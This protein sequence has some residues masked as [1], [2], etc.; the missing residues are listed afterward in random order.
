MKNK[1]KN[2]FNKSFIVLFAIVNLS[3][4]SLAQAS[5]S[6][7]EL[8]TLANSARAKEGLGNLQTNT[9][10]ESAAFAKAN[11][12][13]E[14][15]YFAHASPDGKTPWDF[16]TEAGYSYVY[17]G[18]NLAIGYADSAELHNAWM[19]SAS[20]RDNI[21][22]P[23]FRD[24]GVAVVSGQYQGGETTVVVQMF[25]STSFSQPGSSGSPVVASADTGNLSKT[26]QF[27]LILEKTGFSPNKI[28]AGEDVNFKV[29]LTGEATD[30]FYSLGDQKIDLK[31]SVKAE[32]NSLEKTYEKTEKIEKEGDH[33]VTLTVSDKWGNREAK[34][35][36]K[37]T[38]A[39]KVI[40]KNISS[41]NNPLF[42]A[43]RDFVENNISL[44]ALT[45][46]LIT[47]SIAGYFIFRFRKHGK[48]I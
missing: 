25:G 5:V 37:L 35:L 13:L 41:G 10:L 45:M 15:G 9:K 43:I 4:F 11:D 42:G 34:D 29:T 22:N 18:E 40:T 20:H 1:Y 24:I 2:L 33:T 19:N 36:G 17:A 21:M 44:I 26:K 28:F 3:Y 7:S 12:M 46:A 39:K 6:S 16:I 32:Q 23:N 47:F 14:K 8:V 27:S 30:I 38:V 31:E 48:F